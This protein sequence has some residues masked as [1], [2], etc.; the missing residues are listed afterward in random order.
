M[1]FFTELGTQVENANATRIAAM[2]QFNTDQGNA[3]A[4]FV[5]QMEDSRDK[6]NSNMGA[7]IDQSNANWR[8]QINTDNTALANETNRINAQNLLGLNSAAQNQLWQRYRDEAQW[9]LQKAE[10]ASSRAHSFA[11]TSQQN[12]FSRETY[13]TE[14]TDNLYSE[15]GRAILYGIFS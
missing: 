3:T 14:F 9:V 6:F 12:D 13:E 4:R 5:S 11:M 8:R 15:M 10:N 2:R 7:Q 1:Q